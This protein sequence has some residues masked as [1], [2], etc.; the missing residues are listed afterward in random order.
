MFGARHAG[1]RR[2]DYGDYA[3]EKLLALTRASLELT[4]DVRTPE[5]E[6]MRR[7]WPRWV[8]PPVT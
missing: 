1:M 3:V 5:C 6:A 4:T 2:T 8:E 7:S